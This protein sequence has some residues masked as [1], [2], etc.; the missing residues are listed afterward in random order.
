M[1]SKLHHFWLHE[2]C[3]VYLEACKPTLQSDSPSGEACKQ[4]LYICISVGLRLLHP[5]MPFVTEEL[6]QHLPSAH[7]YH[8]SCSITKSA[9]PTHTETMTGLESMPENK[10]ETLDMN[11]EMIMDIVK[12]IRSVIV[13]LNLVKE[14]PE[15]II[16]LQEQNEEQLAFLNTNA[17]AIQC[18]SK[19][20][21]V[22]AFFEKDVQEIQRKECIVCSK[23]KFITVFLKVK[24]LIDVNKE[25]SKD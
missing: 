20:G 23:G 15:S 14:K 24:G 16:S 9:F 25:V 17:Y 18:L 21:P 11:M 5:S 13:N 7:S 4:T 8:K 19:I 10:A 1:I 6:F 22:H 3:D 12:T 2:F